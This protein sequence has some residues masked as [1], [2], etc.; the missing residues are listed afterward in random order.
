MRLVFLVLHSVS[1]TLRVR[2]YQFPR[3]R[4][5]AVSCW[6]TSIYLVLEH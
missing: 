2:S 4:N 6:K 5:A 3:V 1:E